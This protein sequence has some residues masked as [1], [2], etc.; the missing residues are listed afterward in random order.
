[1]AEITIREYAAKIGKG[2]DAVRRRVY[3]GRLPA[4]KVGKQWLIEEET[5]YLDAR[6]KNGEM[7]GRVKGR[8]YL[9][10]HM[11][12]RIMRAG[13]VDTKKYRYVYAD[14]RCHA[15]IKR[16]PL[17]CLDTP[18]AIDKWEIVKVLR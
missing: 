7:A 6:V 1:M 8:A 11:E 14:E 4:R 17:E 5:P 13:I 18:A 16:I 9:R 2:Y 15:Y 10:P 3:E 12:E